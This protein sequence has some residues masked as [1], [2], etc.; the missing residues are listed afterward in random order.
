MRSGCSAGRPRSPPAS[1]RR[2][3]A[4]LQLTCSVGVATTKFVAKL[5]SARCKP[6]GLLVVPAAGVLDFLHPLPVT[7]LWGVGERTAEP[8]APAR[9][10]DRRRSGRDPAGHPAPGGRRR[11]R[12]NICTSWRNGRDERAVDPHEVE[13]SIS[14]DR[15]LATST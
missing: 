6:D 5:A 10:P 11:P 1:A 13:K 15:T 8:L 7:V 3:A 2:V 4:E 12:P 14:S 9:H